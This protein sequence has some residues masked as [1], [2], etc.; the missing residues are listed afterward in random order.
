MCLRKERKH[1]AVGRQIINFTRL[2]CF[3]FLFGGGGKAFETH[4]E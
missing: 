3:L 4:H 1:K 2:E